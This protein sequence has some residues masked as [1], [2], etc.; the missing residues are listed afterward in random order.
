MQHGTIFIKAALRVCFSLCTTQH[1]E[2]TSEVNTHHGSTAPHCHHLGH[3]D[4]GISAVH[5]LQV[6]PNWIGKLYI[7]VHQCGVNM[8]SMLVIFKQERP[9]ERLH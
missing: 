5:V 7:P 8:L 6:L 2:A 4:F 3:T 1:T 9:R